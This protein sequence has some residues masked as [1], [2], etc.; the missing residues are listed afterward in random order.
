[1]S[2]IPKIPHP[3]QRSPYGQSGEGDVH[4]PSASFSEAAGDEASPPF[5]PSPAPPAT[6]SPPR[7][8]EISAM[9]AARPLTSGAGA[10]RAA[11]SPSLP[12]N[13]RFQLTFLRD[14]DSSDL[15]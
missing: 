1:M 3:P 14:P 5:S 2:R 8:R 10:A 4:V 9:A 7:R 6:S 12:D 15:H 11:P 13:H